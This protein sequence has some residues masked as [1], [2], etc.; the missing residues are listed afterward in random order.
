MTIK[1]VRVRAPR[2]VRVLCPK[3][4]RIGT[5]T[6]RDHGDARLGLFSALIERRA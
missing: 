3:G 6:M 5:I 4:H 2:K 1:R